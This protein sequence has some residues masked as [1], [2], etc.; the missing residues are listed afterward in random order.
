MPAHNSEKKKGTQRQFKCQQIDT[1]KFVE[2][3]KKKRKISKKKRMAVIAARE[4]HYKETQHNLGGII[5]LRHIP[6]EI[7]K[8]GY[9]VNREFQSLNWSTALIHEPGPSHLEIQKKNITAEEVFMHWMKPMFDHMRDKT[10]DY[11]VENEIMEKNKKDTYVLTEKRLHN[12]WALYLA[13]GLVR[14]Q[15]YEQAWEDP[16]KTHGLFGN[17]FFSDTMGR[18]SYHTINRVLHADIPHLVEMHN[19]MSSARRY[20]SQNLSI[21]DDKYKWTGRGGLKQKND[22]K[23]DK[24]GIDT[25]KIID[26]SGYCYALVFTDTIDVKLLQE[27]GD[28]QH[29]A[30]IKVLNRYIPPGAY[31]YYF[32]A[33][34][35]SD[36]DT[37]E[38]LSEQGRQFIMMM[39]NNKEQQ[40]WDILQE[41]LTIRQWKSIYHSTHICC[42]YYAKNSKRGRSYCNLVFNFNNGDAVGSVTNYNKESGDKEHYIAPTVLDKYRHFHTM[43]DSR[44]AQISHIRNEHKLRRPFRAQLAD[45]LYSC[46]HNSYVQYCSLAEKEN[47]Y[48]FGDFLLEIAQALRFPK[49]DAK[50]RQVS[51][52]GDIIYHELKHASKS[53]HCRICESRKV[54]YCPICPKDRHGAI[55]LCEGICALKFHNPDVVIKTK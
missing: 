20:P 50:Y 31:I 9:S 42:S 52:K 38:Y 15:Q 54:T 14:Y 22:K 44:K 29:M 43:V 41:N 51:H 6:E 2:S 46:M 26:E 16:T 40:I 5:T 49:A 13:S 48:R 18:N 35:L 8:K 21:D 1:F 34:I 10:N 4:K 12:F 39:A 17:P 53:L 47:E 37:V 27:Q 33:G 3:E 55:H 45:I 28:N 24:T 19:T 25:F 30:V 23:A 32:D 7:K 11:C 36:F